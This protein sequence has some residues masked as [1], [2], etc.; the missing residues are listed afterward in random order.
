M[1]YW[2]KNKLSYRARLLTTFVGPWLLAVLF[3]FIYLSHIQRVAGESSARRHL[4]IVSDMLAFS[5]A[6]GLSEGNF[7]LVQKAFDWSRFDVNVVYIGILDERNEMIFQTAST[8]PVPLSSLLHEPPGISTIDAGLLSVAPVGEA[9]K[10]IGT[11]ILL[12]SLEGVRQEIRSAQT[13]ALVASIILLFVGLWGTRLLARQAAEL[14]TARSEAERQAQT[15]RAQADTLRGMNVT[16]EKSNAELHCAQ[17]DLQIAHDNLELRVEERTAALAEANAALQLNQIHL[18][19]AMMAARMSPWKYDLKIREFVV[20]QDLLALVGET[21][22]NPT[23]MLKYIYEGDREQA[24]ASLGRTITALEPC[25]V[26]CRI[27]RKDGSLSWIALYGRAMVG[28]DGDPTHVVGLVMDINDRKN[29][30]EALLTSLNEKEIL[31]KEVHHRVK[32]NM[33]VISSLLSLQSSHVRDEFDAELFRESQMRVKS[34]AIV[35]ERLYR[36]PDLS[37]IEFGDYAQAIVDELL[38]SYRRSGIEFRTRI[39]RVRF[40]VDTAIP[41]GLLINE[42]VTNAIKHA[43]PDG[44]E[45]CIEIS[46][47]H[48]AGRINVSVSDNGV[49]LP[50][51]I[52]FAG[53]GTLGVTIIR[54]L[55]DQ[56]EGTMSVDRSGGTRITVSFPL[57]ELDPG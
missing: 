23:E 55:T 19:M 56:L 11:V 27:R 10:P 35:H 37:S 42:L 53:E 41:C 31:L 30:E 5:V 9:G 46:A 4:E 34:M 17:H 28:P 51:H 39:D 14:V 26:E 36:S 24:R 43:F 40:G 7:T 52:D 8:P 32:N 47:T 38:H 54:A 20:P 16:L 45:G 12:Y 50:E 13:T 22:A 33:Q 57:S 29:S 2:M 48:E 6:A 3:S 25:D 18:G 44:R 49:G 21:S 15:V 1:K